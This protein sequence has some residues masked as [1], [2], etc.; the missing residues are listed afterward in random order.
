MRNLSRGA[1]SVLTLP[2]LALLVA[3]VTGVPG[4]QADKWRTVNRA[5]TK[6]VLKN[7]PDELPCTYRDGGY[8][9]NYS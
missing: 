4:A 7:W 3:G 5:D 2:V 9:A 6:V 8:N 1:R